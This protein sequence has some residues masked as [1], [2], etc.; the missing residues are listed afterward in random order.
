LPLACLKNAMLKK[1][2]LVIMTITT[3]SIAG[4][5][6]N[7]LYRA[8]I[9]PQSYIEE[10]RDE[11]IDNFHK[12]KEAFE[13]IRTFG[14]KIKILEYFILEDNGL[15]SF[16]VTDSLMTYNDSLLSNLIEIGGVNEDNVQDIKFTDTNSV[17]VLKKGKWYNETN[18]HISYVGS[19]E[20][21]ALPQI[22]EYIDIELNTLE[23][24]IEKLKVIDCK[25]FSKTNGVIN[26]MHRGFFL[27][28]LNYVIPFTDSINEVDWTKIED[29]FYI[30]YYDSGLN[31]D[32]ADWYNY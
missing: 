25:G 21:L 32:I 4:W 6:V 10:V 5:F 8:Y 9:G 30:E 22:L 11:M 23:T 7:E 17:N 27:E 14:S 1:F 26:L 16:S 18:W 19:K 31:C 15:I 2:I 29:G 28:S 20:N 3:L 12:N 13:D 24:L